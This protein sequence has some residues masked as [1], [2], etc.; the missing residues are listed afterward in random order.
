MLKSI[1][2]IFCSLLLLAAPPTGAHTPAAQGCG[3][4]AGEYSNEL[5]I[6][7]SAAAS[8]GASASSAPVALELDRRYAIS[9]D[10]QGKLKFRMEPGRAT[11]AANARGGIFSFRTTIAGLYRVSLTSRHWIDLIDG[12]ARVESRRHFGPGGALIHKIVEFELPGDRQMI[13]QLSG[14]DDVTVGLAI[15]AATVAQTA[16]D[17]DA[18]ANR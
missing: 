1:L 2:T 12:N 3:A 9:L 10:E 16:V 17:A 4:S 15:T 13:L 11:R 8:V 5:A 18:H 6:M 7:Q 14:R